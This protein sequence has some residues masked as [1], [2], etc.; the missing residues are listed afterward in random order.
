MIGGLAR[1]VFDDSLYDMVVIPN[2]CEGS[3][4]FLAV[5]SK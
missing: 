5:R 2:A 4:G 1:Q 3:E